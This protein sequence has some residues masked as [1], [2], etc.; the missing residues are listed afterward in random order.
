MTNSRACRRWA[1]PQFLA[2][3]ASLL[4]VGCETD[5]P[6]SAP[7]QSSTGGGSPYALRTNQPATAQARPRIRIKAG[8]TAPYTD[9]AGN[10]WLADRGF[11]DGETVDRVADLPIANTADPA[12]YRT[13]R[14]SMTAFSQPLPNGQYT[15]KLYFVETYEGITAPGDR[16]F[17]FHVEG[18]EFKDFDIWQ[19]AG[20]PLR[21]YVESVPVVIA[22]GK[23]DITFTSN[24]QNPAINAIE[25]IPAP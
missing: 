22:D 17:T 21:A 19:K 24:I 7:P 10:V 3:V 8:V 14:Y 18:R 20:G 4:I 9:S 5:K 25:I 23:L 15:V 12:I 6:N 13:E 11:A 16:V 2:A 1:V